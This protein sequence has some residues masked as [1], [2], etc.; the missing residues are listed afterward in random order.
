MDVVNTSLS[1]S[2]SNKKVDGAFARF[3]M[4]R[5]L[6]LLFQQLYTQLNEYLRSILSEMFQKKPIEIVGRFHGAS[7][8]FYEIVKLGSYDAVCEHMIEQVFRDLAN[9]NRNTKSLVKQ[10]ISKTGGNCS[11]GVIAHLG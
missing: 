6:E 5:N 10:I 11:P 4:K 7:L 1:E 3:A 2:I 9:K 8:K